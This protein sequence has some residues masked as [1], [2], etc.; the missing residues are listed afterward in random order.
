MK[1]LKHIL[2]L[3]LIF[4]SQLLHA[5]PEE[6]QGLQD[7][8]G[9]HQ[10]VVLTQEMFALSAKYGRSVLQGLDVISLDGVLIDSRQLP[11]K[12][13]DGVSRYEMR[14]CSK[15]AGGIAGDPRYLILHNTEKPPK[16]IDTDLS[17]SRGVKHEV[18]PFWL[19]EL[20]LGEKRL[21]CNATN[22]SMMEFNV[23]LADAFDCEFGV[24]ADGE[25]MFRNK[26][27]DAKVKYPMYVIK[28]RDSGNSHDKSTES[29][30]SKQ[31]NIDLSDSAEGARPI[32]KEKPSLDK[33]K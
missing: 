33:P 18:I 7:A 20:S 2:G 22:F 11:A 25:V 8:T 31:K 24:T 19:K 1:F 4:S 9:Q 14:F 30:S 32:V 23:L 13:H 6:G 26:T 28:S 17:G 21:L 15:I 3:S 12:A 10:L 27:A 16:P 29:S 5:K